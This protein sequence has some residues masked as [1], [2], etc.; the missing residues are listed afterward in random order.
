MNVNEATAGVIKNVSTSPEV[1]AVNVGTDTGYLRVAMCVRV[2]CRTNKYDYNIKY[3][4]IKYCNKNMGYRISTETANISHV[5]RVKEYLHCV[6]LRANLCKEV[7][8]QW[9]I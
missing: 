8:L 9:Y 5:C 2:R 6:T 1:T 7:S 3:K 4:N